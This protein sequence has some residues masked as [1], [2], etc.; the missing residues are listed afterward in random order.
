MGSTRGGT[1][2]TTL[3]AGTLALVTG[4]AVLAGGVGAGTAAAADRGNGPGAAASPP[5][6]PAQ[7]SPRAVLA[8][9]QRVLDGERPGSRAEKG[10]EAG[11]AAGAAATT[12]PSVTI[13]LRDLRAVLP[14]LDGDEARQAEALLARPTDGQADPWGDG[15]TVRSRRDCGRF[16]CVHWVPR[17]QDAPPGRA[18]VDR[19]LRTVNQV[20]RRQVRGMGYR[21]PLADGRRGGN[22]KLDVYLSDV[23]AKG[24]YGYCAPE[25]RHQRFRRTASG[26]CVL[27][28]DFSRAEFGGSPAEVMRVTAVH[29]LFH[30]VQFAHDYLEDGWLMESTSTWMEERLADG[31]DDNRQYLPAG[32]LVDTRTPLDLSR[33]GSGS[34][35]G[36]WIWWENLSG[37]WGAGIVGQ[38]WN[39]AGAFKGAPDDYSVEALRR[40]LGSRGGFVAAYARFAADN[41]APART[42]PEGAAYPRPRSTVVRTVGRDSRTGTVE[43]R[44]S[45]LTSASARLRPG[46]NLGGAGWRLRVTVTAPDR[47]TGPAAHVVVTRR[48]GS[49]VRRPVTLSE[50]GDGRTVVPFDPDRVASVSVTLANASTRYR[51]RQ[52][53][54]FACQGTSRD[55]GRAYSLAYR[56]FRG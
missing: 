25:R 44:L 36:N 7:A 18:W 3:A 55:D 38:V 30:A 1:I 15:Y 52:G 32:Q 16:V 19:T 46:R 40:V 12:D 8:T 31:V 11:Q 23:G 56:A 50:T 49:V 51:C 13:A 4:L 33:A 45:H 5:E 24:Y 9:A 17:T 20:F 43:R 6:L 21:K 27:D 53:T 41:L 14:R 47:A 2:R 22:R 54:D 42:Y 37:R 29:E 10:E 48:D 39:R 28:N 34:H 35:Y 26:F